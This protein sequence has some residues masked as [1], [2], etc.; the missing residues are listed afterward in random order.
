MTNTSPTP[1]STDPSDFANLSNTE[2]AV[3]RTDLAQERTGMSNQRTD[4]AQERTDL[5][6]ERNRM[7]GER[8]L[9][10]WIRTSLAM[11]SFGFG[12]DRFFAYLDKTQ[13]NQNLDAISEERLLGLSFITLGTFGLLAAIINH[14]Q[15]L[16]N[17]DREQYTYTPRWSLAM[18]VAIVLVFI[19]L[20]TYFP[21]ITADVKLRDI[22]TFDSQIIRNLVSLT[23]FGIMLTMGINFSLR[24]LLAFWKQSDLVL[25]AQLAVS[26]LMP[27]IAIVLLWL[28]HPPNAV[29]VGLILLAASPGAPLLTKRVQMA[30]G[31][32][33]YGASLQ[34]TLSLSA[35]LITP[36][37]LSISGLIFPVATATVDSL[38]IATQIALVQLLPLSIG[39]GL[40]QV[41]S[42]IADE[43]GDFLTII[44]NTLFVV[45]AI[46]LLVMSLDLISN[47]GTLPIVL[48]LAIASVSLTIGHFLGGSASETR[49]AVAI[50]SIARNVG[51]A[52]FIAVL[53]QQTQAIPVILSYLILAALV[54]FPYSAW[55]RRQIKASSVDTSIPV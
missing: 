25:R 15:N 12:I 30:G 55:M 32:F 38:Q 21:L 14:W 27:A 42:E 51:L 48:I 40:R 7:A 52:I 26:V 43:I 8:T 22:I 4:L 47:L 19:G 49:A 41:G 20:A 16:K 18:V 13:A 17:L 31:S 39:L 44:A 46:F 5:A 10:A 11:I 1:K 45:L 9:L 35:V 34:V 33:N 29:I 37:I 3:I 54:A 24:D 53:N 50:A 36:I 23:V 6:K 28:L 2:L